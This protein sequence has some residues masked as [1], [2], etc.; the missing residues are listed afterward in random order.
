MKAQKLISNGVLYNAQMFCTRGSFMAFSSVGFL[1]MEN[2]LR[3]GTSVYIASSK[4]QVP[5]L[6][7]G[8]RICNVTIIKSLRHRSTHCQEGD[9]MGGGVTKRFSQYTQHQAWITRRNCITLNQ[10]LKSAEMLGEINI[11]TQI[12]FEISKS[13]FKR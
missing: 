4:G 12:Y 2:L 5:T 7:S 11:R 3:H 1:Y 6:H 10:A 8:I 9:L 13:R